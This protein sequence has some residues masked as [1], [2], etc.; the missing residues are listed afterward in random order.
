MPAAQLNE[1]SAKIRRGKARAM[2]LRV[3][4]LMAVGAVAVL[5]A[6]SLSSCSGGGSGN[7][8]EAE[9]AADITQEMIDAATEEGRVVVY[10]NPPEDTWAM[11]L[12]AF[13][14]V[15]P[16]I[17]VET[18]DL[19]GSEMVQR[20]LSEVKTGGSSADIIFDS[21]AK[22]F[23]DL[24]NNIE[25][26]TSIYDDGLED[27]VNPEA[28]VY[29]VSADPSVIVYNKLVLGED[30]WP[31]G[32]ADLVKLAQTHPGTLTTYDTGNTTGYTHMWGY[33][34]AV[35]DKAWDQFA[36]LL[37]ET[38]FE[39]SG[40]AMI[41]KMSQGEYLAGYF[42]SGLARGLLE[43]MGFADILGWVYPT[44]A[45][46]LMPRYASVMKEAKHPNAATLLREF[47]LSPE[48]QKLM[49][50]STLTAVRADVAES[51]GEFSIQG[52]ADQVG[53]QN[54]HFIEFGDQPYADRDEF[55]ARVQKL[56]Q[57]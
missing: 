56:A 50:Q 43:P 3:R 45:A 26:T 42:Q 22:T 14:K 25:P 6:G 44:E 39:S 16:G 36:T 35:G 20:Y 24:A 18:V 46:V 23:L 37:P 33:V 9:A 11:L 47:M 55:V 52:I 51:C 8:I 38:T 10:G 15:Y 12:P 57:G 13:E 40:G 1:E 54:V 32:F 4:K 28:G 29:A 19:S 2:K 21:N 17:K 30:E 48:G 49:C 27:F 5:A 41:Q 34:D 7:N 31:E 53:E